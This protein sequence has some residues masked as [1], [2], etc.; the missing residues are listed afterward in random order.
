MRR[1]TEPAWPASS[2]DGWGWCS[3]VPTQLPPWDCTR[4]FLPWVSGAAL[5]MLPCVVCSAPSRWADALAQP[6]SLSGGVRVPLGS[7]VPLGLPGSPFMEPCFPGCRLCC[8]CTA[9]VW[10]AQATREWLGPCLKLGLCWRQAREAGQRRG[11]PT[12]GPVWRGWNWVLGAGGFCWLFLPRVYLRCLQGCSEKQV[13]CEA[14]GPQHQSTGPSALCV[15]QRTLRG[16]AG[17][18][19]CLCLGCS[20]WVSCHHHH[21]DLRGPR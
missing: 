21:R 6:K 4:A 18:L 14:V 20:E 8:P 3:R 5:A 11:S 12:L 17:G 13:T 1:T 10:A 16:A 9:A 2:S 15:M 19:T 7:Q